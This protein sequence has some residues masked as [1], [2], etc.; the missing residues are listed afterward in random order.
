MPPVVGSPIVDG[1]HRDR[2]HRRDPRLSGHR[3]P[4]RPA[5]GRRGGDGV[6]EPGAVAMAP[7]S[8]VPAI[9]ESGI[10][11]GDLLPAVPDPGAG[12]Q[13]P[14]DVAGGSQLTIGDVFDD[15]LLDGVAAG[16]PIVA[17]VGAASLTAISIGRAVCSPSAAVMFTNVR[18]VP[19][20]VGSAVERT[21][22]VGNQAVSRLGTG[23]G[24]STRRP[25][26][27]PRA[28]AR[29]RRND[30]RSHPGR[31]RERRRAAAATRTRRGFVTRGS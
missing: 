16:L 6:D 5:R 7:T 21:A 14:T 11:T 17:A 2:A 31:I 18:L 23:D 13:S 15:A 10:P 3:A 26:S 22:M 8:V 29:D 12:I 9:P 20:L 27:V 25:A 1:A 24:G 4:V 19:C 28:S 30:R